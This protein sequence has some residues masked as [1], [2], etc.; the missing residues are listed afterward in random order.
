MAL[1]NVNVM[2]V[3]PY[4]GLYIYTPRTQ[5]ERTVCMLNFF[6]PN[7]KFRSC[8]TSVFL[9]VEAEFINIIYVPLTF[10]LESSKGKQIYIYEISNKQ[11]LPC[12]SSR[13]S[14]LTS[15]DTA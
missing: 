3:Q 15:I 4:L 14:L 2:C 13:L 8:K 7:K 10:K 9:Q 6:P 11:F 1:R 12:I 5:L